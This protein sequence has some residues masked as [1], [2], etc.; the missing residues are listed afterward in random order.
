M[1]RG[2]YS[3]FSSD[4]AIDF[5]TH[6][7]LV[8]AKGRGIMYH[9]PSVIAVDK[10]L[11]VI[12]AG[13][14]VADTLRVYKDSITVVRPIKGGAITRLDLAEKLI[15]HCI[16]MVHNGKTWVSPRVVIGVNPTMTQ[17]ERHA[18]E[19]STHRAGAAEVYLME[20]DIAAAHG[21]GVPMSEPYGIM[22]VDIG[23]GTT[24]I[25][26]ISMGSAV[27]S[28]SIKS[29][30]SQLDQSIVEYIRRKYNLLVGQRTAE[31]IKIAIGSA[32]PLDEGRTTRTMRIAGRH[33]L[34]GELRSIEINDEEIRE[35]LADDVTHIINAVRRA[36]ERS[37]PDLAADIIERGIVLTGGGALLSNLDRRLCIET[38]VPVVIADDALSCV[39]LGIGKTLNDFDLHRRMKFGNPL[40]S[41]DR[42]L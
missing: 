16:R 31:K 7:T 40:Y 22:I 1:M 18:V 6:S 38:G 12:A 3:L 36:I 20:T 29:A 28:Y 35:A 41:T 11:A 26:V 25:S 34:E 13:K 32:F 17:V 42:E 8:Y 39:A 30:G 23:G 15:Q 33:L 37:P 5:G 14:T 19:S 21:A 2:L 27:Y 10:N 9:E 24:D 4:L